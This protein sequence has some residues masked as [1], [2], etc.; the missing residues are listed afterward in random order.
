M[1]QHGCRR[2]SAPTVGNVWH[3]CTLLHIL[4][5]RLLTPPSAQPSLSSDVWQ[6]SP[7]T[8]VHTIGVLLMR[9]VCCC[10]T[11]VESLQPRA[12]C[13][14]FYHTRDARRGLVLEQMRVCHSCCKGCRI[15]LLCCSCR[16]SCRIANAS[17]TLPEARSSKSWRMMR[18]RQAN[19]VF[20]LPE[21]T[22]AEPSAK[23]WWA[24][25]PAVTG[26]C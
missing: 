20:H 15:C 5:A 23:V 16:V 10:P 13:L 2:L 18:K 26:P 11:A 21:G 3:A 1:L 12:V 25:C 14:D 17:C 4:A 6:S 8:T 24:V 7:H 19:L 22:L 9:C